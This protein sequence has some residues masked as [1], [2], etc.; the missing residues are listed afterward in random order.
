MIN[1]YWLDQIPSDQLGAVGLKAAYLSQ[2]KRSGCPVLPGFVISNQVLQTVLEGV[3]WTIPLFADFP[4]SSLRLNIDNA[5]QLQTIAQQLRAAIATAP[6]PKPFLA[7]LATAANALQSPTLILRPSLVVELANPTSAQISVTD[8]VF[9]SS[10]LIAS[11]ICNAD[12]EALTQGI[13][14]LWAD[15]FGAKSLFYWQRLNVPLQQV[16]LAILVQPIQS[17]IAAGTVRSIAHYLELSATVGLGTAI[18][19][20][21][22][23]PDVY[24]LQPDTGVI[25]S[26]SLGQKSVAY[27]IAP[28]T[29]PLSSNTP[30]KM[31]MYLLDDHQR[32]NY[33]LTEAQV[34]HLVQLAHTAQAEMG[35]AIE[36]EWVLFP[37]TTGAIKQYITQVMPQSALP[38]LPVPSSQSGLTSPRRGVELFPDATLIATGLAASPGQAIAR[39]IVLA[40]ST[41]RPDHV[42]P[43]TV[44]IAPTLPLDWM[45]LLQ[46]SMGLILEQGSLTSHSAIVAREIGVPAVM[47]VAEATQHIRSG[48]LIWVD[49]DQG[50]VYRLAQTAIMPEP[51]TLATSSAKSISVERSSTRTQLWVN[52]SQPDQLAYAADLP[53]A[54][55]GL[56]R[57]E[58]LALTILDH[59]HPALWLQQN[60]KAE[61]IRRMAAAIAEF[62]NAFSPR[63]VLYRSF[64]LR[65]HEFS[66]SV[67]SVTPP[68]HPALGVRG[69]YSYVRDSTLFALELQSLL[70]VQQMGYSNVRLMLPFVRTVEEFQFCRQMVH[71]MGLMHQSS[72]QLWMM[73]EVPSVLMLLSDYVAA[74]V[75]GISIGTN[76]LTQLLLGV[77]RDDAEMATAFEE[78]HP[79]VQRAMA[80]LIR[81]ARSLGISCSVCGEATARYPELI[82]NLVQWEIDSISVAPEA[83]GVTYE[84]ILKAEQDL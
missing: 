58:L 10:G 69:T 51:P 73:A 7:D 81:A 82:A 6:L 84:A 16:K 44:L 61:F 36:L 22:V 43:H 21:E 42:Q 41:T 32:S 13:K 72:F 74:G 12:L 53:V 20:G 33:A 63:P 48:E 64:D 38:V 37:D 3:R 24:Q 23:L 25:L 2:L 9:N 67:R 47:G 39:A 15:F 68:S 79:A 50:R 31:E 8:L 56:L 26:Q 30:N 14:R 19:R 46:Q 71:Q 40:D 1:L 34:R 55:V 27:Q 80:Q 65:S 57:A 59:Q 29:T 70:T 28:T 83:V 45:P 52:L 77:D 18:D 54:G 75:H 4:S 66:Q 76:D 49:G 11:Q 78:R 5:Q 17:A 62:A 35:I 60:S